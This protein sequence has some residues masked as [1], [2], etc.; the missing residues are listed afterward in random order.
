MSLEFLNNKRKFIRKKVTE[1]FNRSQAFQNSSPHE[2]LKIQITLKELQMNLKEAD[3]TIQ[4]LIW[5]AEKDESKLEEELSRCSEYNEKIN[6]CLSLLDETP[7]TP[8]PVPTRLSIEGARSVLRSP[9]APLPKFDS[10]EGEDFMKFLTQFEETTSKYNYASYDLLLLLKQ[11]ISGKALTL[12]DTLEHGRQ[13][14]QHAKD[15]LKKAFASKDTIIYNT[16][17]NLSELTLPSKSEP[18]EYI[19]KMRVIMQNVEQHSITV[20]DI[21]RHFFWKGMNTQLQQIFIQLTNKNRPTLQE[22]TDRFFE[23]SERYAMQDKGAKNSTKPEKV[24]EA[25]LAVNVDFKKKFKPC[26]LCST[27]AQNASHPIF[28]CEK[29]ASPKSKLDKLNNLKACIKCAND[30]HDTDSCRYR[31]NNRCVKCNNWHFA[32]LCDERS[33]TPHEPGPSTSK[34]NTSNVLAVPVTANTS[35]IWITESLNIGQNNDSI[36]PTFS[37]KVQKL[38]VRGL[39]DSGCQSNF[40]SRRLANKIK[41]KTIADVV[42]TI[43][44]INASKQYK[45]NLVRFG[46]KF[47][48][49]NLQMDALIIPKIPLDIKLRRLGEIVQRFNDH[50]FKLG[51]EFLCKKSNDIRDLDMIL[52]TK[53]SYCLPLR[54]TVLG[55]NSVY[56]ESPIGV[57]LQGDI[58]DLLRNVKFLPRTVPERCHREVDAISNREATE[59]YRTS[60]NLVNSGEP[61]ITEKDDRTQS[62][63][64]CKVQVDDSALDLALERALN[65]ESYFL[66]YGGEPSNELDDR[67]FN[68][69]HV[70]GKQNPT[71]YIKIKVSPSQLN[72]K[73]FLAG[74]SFLHQDEITCDEQSIT[75]PS[76]LEMIE[77]SQETVQV[78]SR[79]H[80]PNGNRTFLPT[81]KQRK[82]SRVSKEPG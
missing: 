60:A 51:D 36:L 1:H 55:D 26:I 72:E 27:E 25:G 48:D 54:D 2:R 19:A 43:N 80:S 61:I 41:A 34:D 6:V 75:T 13:A 62:I 8:P 40:I 29:Y 49:K 21:M 24:S 68:S 10:K 14:Y 74:P 9:I 47:G 17:K 67:N 81:K 35:T 3:D 46:V 7:T 57:L 71:D 69:C 59:P 5:E 16:I 20:E 28:K 52:G 65:N 38:K 70:D 53:G 79:Q 50:G 77:E 22:L 56:S 15:L 33:G 11:Q 78:Q 12:V 37:C 30:N 82:R 31:F 32:F 18:F 23:A 63:I 4:K 39:K 64:D 76:P 73:C 44:G 45:S 66:S 42:L 58:N